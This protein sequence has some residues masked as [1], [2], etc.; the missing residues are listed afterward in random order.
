MKSIKEI[1]S[2]IA[3]SEGLKNQVS[4]GNIRE[5]VGIF[6]DMICASTGIDVIEV[7]NKNGKAR[8]K[9]KKK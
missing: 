2:A 9:R 6:S 5:I 8:L 1:V 4:V 7:L 3:K